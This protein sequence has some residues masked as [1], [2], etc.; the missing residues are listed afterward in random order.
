[1]WYRFDSSIEIL[2]FTTPYFIVSCGILGSF[3]QIYPQTGRGKNFPSTAHHAATMS[4]CDALALALSACVN[5]WAQSNSYAT[6]KRKQQDLE[7][8]DD[9]EA[10]AA[11]ISA[12]AAEDTGTGKELGADDD[13]EW[14]SMH[15]EFVQRRSMQSKPRGR[16][17]QIEN[18]IS[19]PFWFTDAD[20]CRNLCV[21]H[22]TFEHIVLMVQ[23]DITDSVNP[24]TGR[25]LCRKEFKVA[26][27]LYHLGHGGTWRMT[28]NVAA[29]GVATARK[30]VITVAAAVVKHMK[31]RYMPGTPCSDRLAR[32]TRKFTERQGLGNVVMTID[33]CHVPWTPN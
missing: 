13:D 19:D 7:S 3:T 2:V 23:S 30:Y 29:I 28:G 12:V 24:L 32:V 5:F 11:A 27:Y 15:T 21:T 4:E 31:A 25:I 26:V 22:R 33:G 8:D 10:V 20:F 17:S 14:L 1:M 9:V 16:Q 18:W 6:R